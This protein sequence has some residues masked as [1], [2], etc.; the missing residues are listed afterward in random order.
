MDVEAQ[1]TEV[2]QFCERN[3]DRAVQGDYASIFLVLESAEWSE[4][5]ATTF[6]ELEYENCYILFQRREGVL[7]LVQLNIGD[8]D[9]D[10]HVEYYQLR[11]CDSHRLMQHLRLNVARATVIPEVWWRVPAERW[12]NLPRHYGANNYISQW[13]TYPRADLQGVFQ[14]KSLC[15][16]RDK[17][18]LSWLQPYH[19]ASACPEFLLAVLP[20]PCMLL[21]LVFLCGVVSPSLLQQC[22]LAWQ[23]SR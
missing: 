13:P 14:Q 9:H 4:W 15:F 12:F 3:A 5:F 7:Q 21:V 2:L 8:K 1:M 18:L 23:N 16:V 11:R 10:D 22:S 17:T 19:D 6:V 20:S